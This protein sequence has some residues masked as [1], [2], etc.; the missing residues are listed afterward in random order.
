MEKFK[1]AKWIWVDKE[2]NPD[3]HA[4]FFAEFDYSGG[5]AFCA[6]SCDSDYA[7]FINGKFVSSNQYADFEHYKSYDDIEI[8]DY[9]KE[10][11]NSFAVHVWYFGTSSMRYFRADAGLIFKVYTKN[12]EL[13]FSNENV[14]SRYSLRYESGNKKNITPQLGYTVFYDAKKEDEWK[15]GG[16][17]D[18]TK[19]TVIEKSCQFV[20][21]PVKK[22]SY[23]EPVNA[24]LTYKDDKKALFDLQKECVGL[25]SFAFYSPIEQQIDVSW[26]E[27]QTNNSVSRNI[28]VRDFSFAFNAKKGVNDFTEYMLRF[29]VRY[30]EFSYRTPV[31]FDVVSLIPSTYPIERAEV[32]VSNDKDREI[33]D[34]CVRTLEL[35]MM[36]HYVD[37]P[38]REQCLYAFDSRNQMLC[39][40]RAFEGGNYEYARANLLLMS[41]DRREDGLLSICFPCGSDLTIPSFSLYYVV[42][43]WEYLNETGDKTL[44]DEVYDKIISVLKVFIKNMKSNLIYKFE[45]S[46]RWNF[47]DWSP[48]MEGTL[49]SAEE[50]KPDFMI[51]ALFVLALDRLEK[52]C[53]ACEK[54]YPFMGLREEIVSAIRKNFL[55]GSGLFSMDKDEEIVTE[56]VNSFAVISGIANDREKEYICK[57]LSRGELISCSLSMKVFKYDALM[58]VDTDK[59]K[60]CVLNE[61]RST[62]G[63]ML[64]AGATSVWETEDGAIAFNNAG[65]L[66]HGWSAIP[67]YVFHR[68]GVVKKL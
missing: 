53:N 35:C 36:E 8:T 49:G 64:D 6:L 24:V 46:N 11:K 18:F 4:E 56:L 13:L 44:V 31:E 3:T 5:K 41:K 32:T 55:L 38:W 37:C 50:S 19:S 62:Y 60:D 59:Y 40:Y 10:G 34:V 14:L 22:N 43:V 21:R 9:L 66:C 2:N 51:N 16:G 7:F 54:V 1:N 26:G 45:E 61:I 68:L 25:V 63:K 48:H 58:G 67:V 17:K 30:F 27:H 29:G 33:Y 23:G 65:S 39:G 28:G 52:I 15:V 20:P 42:S 12:S 47:Y 57:L